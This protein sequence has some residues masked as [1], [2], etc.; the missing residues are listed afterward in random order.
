MVEWQ[1]SV[2][3]GLHRHRGR[4]FP[5]ELQPKLVNLESPFAHGDVLHA[6]QEIRGTWVEIFGSG[7][8]QIAPGNIEVLPHELLQ[9]PCNT[10]QSALVSAAFSPIK[11][12]SVLSVIANPFSS[13]NKGPRSHL[14]S[15]KF[16]SWANP[17]PSHRQL[18]LQNRGALQSWQL[19]WISGELGPEM[20]GS[21]HRGVRWSFLGNNTKR[22][23][24]SGR[25]ES[26]DLGTFHN[27]ID[28]HQ[29]ENEI[30]PKSLAQ[31]D[32]RLRRSNVVLQR[33]R[34]CERV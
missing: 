2:L 12:S 27:K 19:A 13:S 16:Y 11:P 15:Q 34:G 6:R 9:H 17:R 7:R 1:Q 25:P 20:V 4:D 29:R 18:G 21:L 10:N 14:G 30:N 22:K 32:S 24:L 8:D 3:V 28:W 31:C 26:V 23:R 5:S 33:I